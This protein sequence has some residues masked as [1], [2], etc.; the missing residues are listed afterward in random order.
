[1]SGPKVVRIVTREEVIAIC[2]GLLAR[3]REAAR[4]WE[5]TGLRNDLLTNEA[6]EQTRQRVKELEEFLLK[7]R[8]LD[9]QKQVPSEIQFLKV[10]MAK[11]IEQAAKK[12]A[13]SRVRARRLASMARQKIEDANRDGLVLPKDLRTELEAV[14]GGGINERRAE[15]VLAE[16]L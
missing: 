13:D 7:D 8:F 4:Q 9:L 14:A 2:E 11:R 15:A 10:D 1:M 12:A 6:V 16:I 5:K 3:L